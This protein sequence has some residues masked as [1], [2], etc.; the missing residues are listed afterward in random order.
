MMRDATGCRIYARFAD[1]NGGV[2]IVKQ[3]GVLG[4]GAGSDRRPRVPNDRVWVFLET[5]PRIETLW[6]TEHADTNDLPQAAQHHTTTPMLDPERAA[7]LIAALAAH[8]A[9][10]E[11]G[12]G[13]D[14]SS[15]IFDYEN[16]CHRFRTWGGPQ[17]RNAQSV[18]T[19]MLR[20][21]HADFRKPRLAALGFTRVPHDPVATIGF[22]TI[23]DWYAVWRERPRAASR[24]LPL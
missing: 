11:S 20:A 6:A 16:P 19:F 17:L 15:P 14:T 5:A 7:S 1:V 8:R 23:L 4:A 21:M 10:V 22:D 18:G 9:V 24:E 2:V 3:A 12:A 13:P